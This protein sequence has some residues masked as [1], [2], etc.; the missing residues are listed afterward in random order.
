MEKAE[1]LPDG[2]EKEQQLQQ[3]QPP[4]PPITKTSGIASGKKRESRK[5]KMR[6]KKKGLTITC[7]SIEAS[8]LSPPKNFEDSWWRKK[9]QRAPPGTLGAHSSAAA[10]SPASPSP[11]KPLTGV[12]IHGRAYFPDGSEI[13]FFWGRTIHSDPYSLQEREKR[14]ASGYPFRAIRHCTKGESRTRAFTLAEGQRAPSTRRITTRTQ[15]TN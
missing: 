9:Y 13:S 14:I 8:P 7:P 6:R 3:P 5:E 12:R 2:G 4:P 1:G 10:P 11:S 15:R